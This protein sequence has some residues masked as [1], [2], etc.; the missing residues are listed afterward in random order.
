MRIIVI[1]GTG[2]TGSLVCSFLRNSGSEVV[3][4]ARSRPDDLMEDFLK[5]DV[6]KSP[7]ATVDALR[8]FD[9]VVNCS[10]PFE[11]L[12]SIVAQRCIEAG[13]NYIDVNDSIDAQRSILELNR[14]ATEN[15]VTILS[16]FGLCPGLSTALLL[17]LCSQ[18]DI[19]EIRSVTTDLHIGGDQ[20]SG[21]AAVKS[22]FH[23]MFGGYRVLRNGSEQLL[24]PVSTPEKSEESGYIGYECPDMDSLSS[25]YPKIEDY[26]YRVKF[27]ALP[28]QTISKL[29][30]S[31]LY[32]FPVISGVLS[33]MAAAATTKKAL[34]KNSPR[35]SHLTVGVFGENIEISMRVTGKTSYEFTALT[36][37]ASLLSAAKLSLNYGVF[38][39]FDQPDLMD[40]VLTSLEKEGVECDVRMGS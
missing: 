22:M 36:I 1:G 7:S 13:T 26:T 4:G 37:G 40:K 16:G 10:G 38:T 3:V 23:T 5:I 34:K 2:V 24:M 15:R 27:D 21:A 12:G 39:A 19:N 32:T 31:K 28:A 35:N 8:G 14:H 9:W 11:A 20:A 30:K 17:K 6:R 25:I 29:Q 18:V 33:R